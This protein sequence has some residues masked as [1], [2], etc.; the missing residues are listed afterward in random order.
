MDFK[1][2]YKVLSD[3]INNNFYIGSKINDYFFKYGITGFNSGTTDIQTDMNRGGDI[4]FTFMFDNGFHNIEAR[5]HS[6]SYSRNRVNHTISTEK[7]DGVISRLPQSKKLL[8]NICL[9]KMKISWIDIYLN[10]DQHKELFQG[11]DQI[12]EIRIIPLWL[13]KNVLVL[14][15][16]DKYISAAVENKPDE[17]YEIKNGWRTGTPGMYY[18]GYNENFLAVDRDYF[19]EQVII[20]PKDENQGQLF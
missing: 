9:K 11:V 14:K 8:K 3:I 2:N 18:V 15:E 7:S 4:T 17:A 13:P 16:A 6:K 1:K 10:I 12:D 19:P 20:N 5:I